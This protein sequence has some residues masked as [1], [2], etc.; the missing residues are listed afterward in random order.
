MI[1][2]CCVQLIKKSIIML[3]LITPI[4]ISLFAL[5]VAYHARV[6]VDTFTQEFIDL[7]FTTNPDN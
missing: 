2:G 3:F 4:V 1:N 6:D 7:Q 5:C